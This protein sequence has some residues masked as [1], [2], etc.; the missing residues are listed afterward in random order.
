[1]STENLNMTFEVLKPDLVEF[2]ENDGL[3]IISDEKMSAESLANLCIELAMKFENGCRSLLHPFMTSDR[4]GYMLKVN[5]THGGFVSV[6]NPDG[7]GV[8]HTE[9]YPYFTDDPEDGKLTGLC[10][11]ASMINEAWYHCNN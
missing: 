9:Y 11:L 2:I 7:T 3:D 1:M 4:K 8:S 10:S 6:S 5:N